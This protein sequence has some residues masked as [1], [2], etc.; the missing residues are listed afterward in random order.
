MKNK[1]I[2]VKEQLIHVSEIG[3]QDYICLTD[4]AKSAGADRALHSWL[5]TKS[6]ILFMGFWEQINNANFKVH[7]FVNFKNY[8]GSNSFNPSIVE[9]IERTGAI[10]MISKRGRYGGTYAHKD[11]AFEFGSWLSPEFKL[12]IITEFQ[13][14][15]ER[16]Q[17]SI[18]WDS[19]RYLSRVNYRLHTDS[20]KE[21]LLPLLQLA[22]SKEQ[23]VYMD[24]ADML[25]QIVFGETAAQ[26]KDN[27]PELVTK[28]RNQRDY[29]SLEH[30]IVLANLE[31]LNAHFIIEGKDQSTRMELLIASAQRQFKSFIA[32]RGSLDL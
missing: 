9:W 13:R 6:T 14:L 3:D 25:N 21:I 27:N 23:Y 17:D 11:I 31:N 24:E 10:G 15:K 26:W 12:L 28:G 30:L 16:E 20:I 18:R 8:A 22:K 5:R 4:M 29:A 1:S 2:I 7:E 19:H 32:Q